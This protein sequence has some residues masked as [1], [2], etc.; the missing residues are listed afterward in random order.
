MKISLE[1]AIGIINSNIQSLPFEDIS[2][3]DSMGRRLEE[4]ITADLDNPPFD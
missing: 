3:Y 4:D 2:I 1:D